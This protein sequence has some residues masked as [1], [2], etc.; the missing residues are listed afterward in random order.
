MEIIN[1]L[2]IYLIN[3][4]LSNIKVVELIMISKKELNINCFIII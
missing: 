2:I 4:N 1:I 3:L